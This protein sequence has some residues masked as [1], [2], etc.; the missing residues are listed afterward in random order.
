MHDRLA[1]LVPDMCLKE[2]EKDDEYLILK[3]EAHIFTCKAT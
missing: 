2:R 3:L 1:M